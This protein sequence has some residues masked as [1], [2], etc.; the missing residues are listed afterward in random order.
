MT[1]NVAEVVLPV[2]LSTSQNSALMMDFWLARMNG[3]TSEFAPP[4]VRLLINLPMGFALAM[5]RS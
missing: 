4:T 1:L 2:E 3:S 5:S